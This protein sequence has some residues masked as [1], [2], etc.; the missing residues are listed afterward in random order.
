MP[1]TSFSVARPQMDLSC[2]R[3]VEDD[4]SSEVASCLDEMGYIGTSSQGC[5]VRQDREYRPSDKEPFM[6]ER[7]RDYFCEK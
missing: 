3:V 7:Q 6:S 5:N 1:V 4:S 2:A